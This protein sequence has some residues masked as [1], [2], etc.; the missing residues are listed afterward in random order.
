M[1]SKSSKALWEITGLNLSFNLN[2]QYDLG[3]FNCLDFVFLICKGEYQNI[4]FERFLS[5]LNEREYKGVFNCVRSNLKKKSTKIKDV[6]SSDTF[7]TYH[8]SIFCSLYL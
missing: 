8:F 7:D 6:I 1:S 3:Q 2:L 5:K 4:Y